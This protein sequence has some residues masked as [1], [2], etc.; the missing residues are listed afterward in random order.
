MVTVFGP[1][2][3]PA[4]NVFKFESVILVCG[5]IGV[6]P[7]AS[8]LQFFNSNLQH[9][10]ES[11]D[12]K[13]PRDVPRDKDIPT[14]LVCIDTNNSIFTSYIMDSNTGQA[15]IKTNEISMPDTKFVDFIYD[16]S[17]RTIIALSDIP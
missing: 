6:T 8:I 3:A 17:K 9:D 7:F 13:N 16:I 1:Y 14:V 4:Q 10:G 12:H 2:G 15:I 5:G 11:Y